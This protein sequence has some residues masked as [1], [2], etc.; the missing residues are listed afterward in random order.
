MYSTSKSKK[1]NLTFMPANTF[2]TII[3]K[4]KNKIKNQ[5]KINIAIYIILCMLIEF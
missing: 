1:F 4:K 5:I 2:K 3:F